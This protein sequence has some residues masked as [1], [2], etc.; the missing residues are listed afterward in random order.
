M[1][2]HETNR[3]FYLA[4]LLLSLLDAI[5]PSGIVVEGYT[6]SEI[7]IMWAEKYLT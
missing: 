6:T 2:G 7:E 3:F 5:T 4:L 1:Q